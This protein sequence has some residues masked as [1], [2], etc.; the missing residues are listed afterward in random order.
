MRTKT[1]SLLAR[2]PSTIADVADLNVTP[3]MNMF[4]ILIPFLISM[5]AF[6]HLAAH[7]F[8]L[9]GDEGPGQAS[10]RSDLPLTVAVGVAGLLVAQGD[11]VV[12]ELPRRAGNQDLAALTSLLKSQAP[13]K[14]VLAVDDPI[15]TAEVVACLD[16]CRAAGC[17]DVGLAAG[18]G[19]TLVGEVD[20]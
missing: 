5:S 11:I 9:P 8:H 2:R 4:I 19:V 16:A 10:E 14:L 17:I 6:T 13:D 18:T 1:S 20:R 3:V 7:E 12:A 15:N